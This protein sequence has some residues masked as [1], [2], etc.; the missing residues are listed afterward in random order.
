MFWLKI[1]EWAVY[2]LTSSQHS[3]KSS[4]RLSVSVSA[5]FITWFCW[6]CFFMWVIRLWPVVNSL[7]HCLHFD[8]FVLLYLR[9]CVLKFACWAKLLSHRSHLNCLKPVCVLSW[10]SRDLALLKAYLHLSQGKSL[11]PLCTNWWVLW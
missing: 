9:V 2:V 5:G 7:L 6:L 4:S 10:Y 8:I 1:N 11:F 3:S